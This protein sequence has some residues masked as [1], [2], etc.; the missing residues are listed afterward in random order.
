MKAGTRVEAVVIGGSAGALEPLGALLEALPERFVPAVLVVLHIPPDRP[1]LLVDLF[2]S[3]CRLP[4]L[5]AMDKERVAQGSIY[6]APPDY[7]LQVERGATISLSRDP[8]V[9]FSRP[10]IDVL[11]ESAADAYGEGLTAILLS[12][13]NEDGARG[14]DAVRKARG[15]VWVQSPA[16]AHTNTMPAAAIARAGAD[17]VAPARDL[18]E[19]LVHLRTGRVIAI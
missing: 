17:L 18:A 1:S 7:H 5:E 16:D 10:S 4:V 15:R 19:R 3:R 13:A 12:G 14:L 8:P 11:F 6:F 2:K 9:L